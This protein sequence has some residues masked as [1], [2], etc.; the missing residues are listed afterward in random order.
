[1]PINIFQALRNY[2]GSI[3]THTKILLQQL[4]ANAGQNINATNWF[5]FF[6]FDIMGDIAFGKSFDM[7]VQGKEH[8][9][10]DLLRQGMA[11]MATIG[12]VPW[13]LQILSR[14]PGLANGYKNFLKWSADQSE[15][16]RLVRSA[17]ILL[18]LS[19]F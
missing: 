5:H 7:T 13:S 3:L 18:L 4:R 11:P 12:P 10:L 9:A 14:I 17:Q 16:R 8:F 19:I 2:E 15:E 1:V 6:A